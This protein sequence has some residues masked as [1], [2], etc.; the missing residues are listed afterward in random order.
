MLGA[1][2]DPSE[3]DLAEAGVGDHPG[4]RLGDRRVGIDDLGG[5]TRGVGD[6]NRTVTAPGYERAVVGLLPTGGYQDV[7]V[8]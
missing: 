3:F 1:G 6:H 2:E 7:V 5:W 4:R 8:S